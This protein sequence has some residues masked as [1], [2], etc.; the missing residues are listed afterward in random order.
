MVMLRWLPRYTF[1]VMFSRLATSAV[2]PGYTYAWVYLPL[3]VHRLQD[4]I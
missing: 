3:L 1:S 4:P 2:R